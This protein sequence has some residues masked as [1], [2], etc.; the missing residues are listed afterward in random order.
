MNVSASFVDVENEGNYSQPY[1]A[2]Y[3]TEY[4]GK[5]DGFLIDGGLTRAEMA[6]ISTIIAGL[7][8]SVASGSETSIFRCGESN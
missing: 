2:W 3:S 4:C 1:H 5:G 7:E 8:S 6:K